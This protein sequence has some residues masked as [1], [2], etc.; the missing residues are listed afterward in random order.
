MSNV[1]DLKIGEL[2]LD[3]G[4]V[5]KDVSLFAW[6]G[7]Q[8]CNPQI[9]PVEDMCAYIKRGKCAVQMNYL[10]A[11]YGAI[12]GTYSYLDDVMLFKIGMQVIPLYVQLIK[13]QMVELSLESPIYTTEKGTIMPHPIYKEIRETL[14]AIHVM[15]KDLDLSFSFNK[16]LSLKK[17]GADGIIDTGDPERGDPTY[18]E[19]ISKDTTSMKGIV[20]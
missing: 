12:L 17:P 2:N 20:R 8:E 15:W 5:R 1:D 9:C 7:V 18:Y 14:K 16:G 6:D 10:K 13:L 19:K 3:K 11:L 4:L